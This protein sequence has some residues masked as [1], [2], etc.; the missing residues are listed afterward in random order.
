ATLTTE[1]VFRA[2]LGKFRERKTFFYGHSYSGNPLGC[3]A[4]LAS[5]KIFHEEDT[6]KILE[7]K[8]LFLRG[9]LESLRALPNVSEIRQCGFI[10]GIEVRKATGEA[11]PWHEQTGARVCLAARRQ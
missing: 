10:A 2:F 4:A 11:F 6:L 7:G 1:E 3:A 8:I 5:L 9:L